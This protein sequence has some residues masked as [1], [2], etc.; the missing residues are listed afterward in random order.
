MRKKHCEYL[1]IEC[2]EMLGQIEEIIDRHIKETEDPTIVVPKIKSFLEHCRSSLEYCAQDIFQY[3]VTQSG[4]EK[5]LK[6]KNKNVYFPYGKD[7]AAFN[8]SIEKN[9]PGLSDTL[10]RNLI[11]GLQ[12]F[13]KFKNE[14]FLS[15]MCKLTNEN[16]HDQL[17][18]PSRQINKGISIGGFL[19]ADESS[20]IIV[21]GA[22]FNGLPTGNFAIRNASIEGDI[23]PVLLSEV[24]KWEN[25]FFVFEDQNLNVINFLRLCL[26]EIQDFCASFYKRLEEAFI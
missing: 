26:E 1:F 13:S 6:S 4:R 9:L 20:T 22:T 8:Q 14:K 24:L 3:V 10:I 7:V 2:E 25:G 17:T 16:K 18:E 21:N 12:D 19:S 23:N 15:Y 5:K 11:L